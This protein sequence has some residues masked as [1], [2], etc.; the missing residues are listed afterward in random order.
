M[1]KT[2]IAWT[3]RT[4]NPVTGCT[5]YSAGCAHCYA[6]TMAKRL[7]GMGQ[8]RYA[9][10]F[11]PTLHPEALN[12]PKKVKEPSMFFVC[13]MGDL[14]HKDVPFE[15]IDRVM[16][17]IEMCPQHTFQILT[18][19]PERMYQ[20]FCER[21]RPCHRPFDLPKNI[22]IGTTVE[23]AEATKRLFTFTSILLPHTTNV[24]FLSCEPL[25][26]DLGEL[27]LRD[28]DWVIVGGES[29]NQ[30]RPMQKEWVLD[31]KRQCEEQDVPFFFKQW[32]TYGEDGVKRNKKANGCLLDG[33]VC[34]EWPKG[35]P[36][37]GKE[38]TNE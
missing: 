24:R 30:A 32:G 3:N 12:E 9:N 34:Q 17:I 5:K 37:V 8:K 31:I 19:R 35:Y 22:W 33:K 29:G 28:I 6:E 10:G 36:K 1:S 23:N 38:V 15:F 26:G 20:Y 21:T 13:S 2:S 27:D 18:K 4:W 25:L 11:D 7:Q 16:D 14:F